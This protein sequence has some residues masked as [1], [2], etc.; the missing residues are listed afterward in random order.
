MV[1]LLNFAVA[2]MMGALG[3]LTLLN[4]ELHNIEDIAATPFLATYMIL[5]A[6]LLFVYE[7]VWWVPIPQINR[8]LRK[9]FGFMY[10]LKGKGFYMIFVA[11]LCIGLLNEENKTIEI[12]GWA[13]G[14]AFLAVGILHIFLI[15][16]NPEFEDQYRPPT[17]GLMSSTTSGDN[18]V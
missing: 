3:V 12:L 6:A 17:A 14:I 8:T 15:L 7:L 18:A 2:G 10:G 1:S 5:F 11:F 16:S 9:N 4:F 13:T